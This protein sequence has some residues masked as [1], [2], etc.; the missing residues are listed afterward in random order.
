MGD[1]CYRDT[2]VR[3]TLVRCLA[4]SMALL[5]FPGTVEVVQ[6]AVH[7]AVEGHSAHDDSVDH[8]A[9]DPSDEHGCSGPYHACTC[10]T[11]ATFVA[12]VA[13]IAL[14]S[15]ELG[16]FD[17]VISIDTPVPSDHLD[18]LFRPPTV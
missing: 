2:N 11:S 14:S 13:P 5:M 17:V 6:D 10:C 1:R 8:H 3:T 12:H 4:L 9:D 18:R 7:L 15:N 16:T